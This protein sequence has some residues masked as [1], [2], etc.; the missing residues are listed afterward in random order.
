MTPPNTF[1]LDYTGADCARGHHR[2][3]PGF[4]PV[5]CDPT[6]LRGTR[7]DCSCHPWARRILDIGEVLPQAAAKMPIDN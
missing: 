5:R 2:A 7:C 1:G 6:G 3:C 4:W